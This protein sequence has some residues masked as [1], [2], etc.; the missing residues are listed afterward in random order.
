MNVFGHDD[1]SHDYEPVTSAYP[2]ENPRKQVT[3]RCVT[4]EWLTAVAAE[5]EKV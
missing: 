5:S 4:E 1:I 3:A 2:F